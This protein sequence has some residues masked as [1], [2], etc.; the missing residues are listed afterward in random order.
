MLKSFLEYGFKPEFG[1]LDGVFLSVCSMFFALEQ[2]WNYMIAGMFWVFGSTFI[3][4]KIGFM[5]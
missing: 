1:F 2:S 5:K 3:K 4:K